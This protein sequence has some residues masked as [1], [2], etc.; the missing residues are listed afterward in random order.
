[1]ATVPT[2]VTAPRKKKAVANPKH[3]ITLSFEGKFADL[4]DVLVKHA[5][6]DDRSV[7]QFVLLALRGQFTSP[8]TDTDN[9]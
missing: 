9:A 6:A 7:S 5:D 8:S 1:M 3:T 4:Y 2:P